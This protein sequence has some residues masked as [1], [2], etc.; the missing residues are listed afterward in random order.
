[1][2]RE[3]LVGRRRMPLVG[4]SPILREVERRLSGRTMTALDA[5]AGKSPMPIALAGLGLKTTVADPDSQKQ[6]G[7]SSG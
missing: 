3:V 2:S 4:I 7:K 5:G 6:T 1:M